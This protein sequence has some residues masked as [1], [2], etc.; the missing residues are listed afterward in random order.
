MDT[1]NLGAN[2]GQ[3]FE[4]GQ[5]AGG[6]TAGVGSA[7][8]VLVDTLKEDRAIKAELEG[9]KELI[10]AEEASKGRLLEKEYDLKKPYEQQ[11]S[12]SKNLLGVTSG[13]LP[14][15][16]LFSKEDIE[17]VAPLSLGKVSG[18]GEVLSPEGAIR[19]DGIIYSPE[20]KE[21]GSYLEGYEPK[22]QTEA[23]GVSLRKALGESLGV[24]KEEA[25]REYLGLGQKSLKGISPTS[26][27]GV[28]SDPFKSRQMKKDYPEMYK[29]LEKIVK[30]AFGENALNEIDTE[31]TDTMDTNW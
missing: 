20:G 16:T 19:K 30:G 18:S 5:R 2:A 10:S 21:I 24:T 29:K 8:K 14:L 26:A 6:R 7:L 4:M 22:K 13:I 15:E 9:K 28:L 12:L 3:W 17:Q 31:S 27:L 1:H 25:S 23:G 11:K